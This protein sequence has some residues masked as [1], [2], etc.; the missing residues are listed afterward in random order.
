MEGPVQE[1]MPSYSDSKSTL[2]PLLIFCIL[3]FFG[4]CLAIV[5]FIRNYSVERQDRELELKATVNYSAGY[6]NTA[7]KDNPPGKRSL[8]ARFFDTHASS[9]DRV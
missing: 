5:L 2:N 8:K 4:S 3:S 6:Q 1:S 9:E 7:N